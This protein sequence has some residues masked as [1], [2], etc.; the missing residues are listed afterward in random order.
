MPSALR[1]PVCGSP[2]LDPGILIG[3]IPIVGFL[4]SLYTLLAGLSPLWDPRRQ[5]FHD[6]VAHTNVIKVR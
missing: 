1:A 5:G 6:K 2:I 3:W 4:A